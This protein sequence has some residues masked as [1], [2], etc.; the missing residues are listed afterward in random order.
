MYPNA[1][2]TVDNA[3]AK[4]L[5]PLAVCTTTDSRVFVYFLNSHNIIYRAIKDSK[6][7]NSAETVG[8]NNH[9][10]A[11]KSTQLAVISNAPNKS[12]SLFY[13]KKSETSYSRLTDDWDYPS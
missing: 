7:W 12:N 11:D 8:G 2:N 6:G 13:I 1:D 4:S 10:I 3:E 5:T 9:K